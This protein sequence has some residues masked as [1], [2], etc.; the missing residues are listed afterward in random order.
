[1][2]SPFAPATPR[3]ARRCDV[4]STMTQSSRMMDTATQVRRVGLSMNGSAT[5]TRTPRIPTNGYMYRGL[6]NRLARI[7]GITRTLIGT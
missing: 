5:R 7:S 1:M 3:R 4:T 2:D 6:R